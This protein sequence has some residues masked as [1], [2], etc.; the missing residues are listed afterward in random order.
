MQLGFNQSFNL[1][2]RRRKI[3]KKRRPREDTYHRYRKIIFLCFP[4]HIAAR[5]TVCAR[6]RA[7]KSLPSK[8]LY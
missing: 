1:N 6:D 3:K 2:L 8:V 5:F 4:L 7:F